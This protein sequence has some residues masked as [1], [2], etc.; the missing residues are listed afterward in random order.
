MTDAEALEDGL[1]GIDAVLPQYNQS[2]RLTSEFDNTITTVRGV[3]AAYA[4]KVYLELDEGRFF[5]QSEY[6]SRARVAVVGTGVVEDLFGGINPIGRIVRIDGT[7]FEVIGI[8][9][10]QEQ[11]G[12]GANGNDDVYIPLSTGY[13]VLFQATER[14]TGDDLVNSIRVSVVNLDDVDAVK[15]QIETI[16]RDEHGLKD[17]E[18]DDFSVSD[19]RSLLDTASQITGILTVLLGAIA[20][21]SLVVGGIGIMNISLVSVTERTREIGL[22]KALGARSSSILRQFL[23]ETIFLSVLGGVIGVLTGVGI[24]LL[25]TASGLLETTI[26]WDSIALGLGFSILVGVFFGVYPATR[27]SAL[28]PIEALRYE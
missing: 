2:L 1:T 18:D 17:D 23:I 8:L 6:D 14:G 12:P 7:R 4:E 25:V 15:T 11:A 24:A 3:G 21:I 5:N 20:S 9:E 27:A 16:L 10:E 19:Q 26:T 13:R 28:Q 22:R